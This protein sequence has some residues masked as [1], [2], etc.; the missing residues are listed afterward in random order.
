MKLVAAA[1]AALF[2]M[3]GSIGLASGGSGSKKVRLVRKRR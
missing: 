1:G 3:F 2:L